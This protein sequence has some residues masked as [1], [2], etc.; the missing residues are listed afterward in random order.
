MSKPFEEQMKEK[1]FRAVDRVDGCILIKDALR[2]M[3]KC[4]KACYAKGYNDRS[5][6]YTITSNDVHEE[7]TE[8]LRGTK[9]GKGEG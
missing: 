7:V 4:A 9:R 2:I 1:A 3:R 8:I 6:F 5:D